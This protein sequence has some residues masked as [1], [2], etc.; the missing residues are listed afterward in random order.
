MYNDLKEVYWLNDMK[1]GVTDFVAKCSNCQQVKAEHQRPGGLAQRVEIPMWKWEMINIDFVVGI[2]CTP[3]FMA[4]PFPSFLIEGPSSQLISRRNFS[5][6]WAR[7]GSWDDHL[8]LIE[9]AYYNNFHASIQMAPFEALYGRRCRSPI[10]WFEVG[11]GELIG[12]DLVHQAIEKRLGVQGRRLGVLEGIPHEGD[13]AV[14]KEGEIESEKVVGDPSAIVPVETIE[15][16]EELSYE[17]IPVTILD[18][19]VQKFRIKEIASVK[20]L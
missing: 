12:P 1:R 20:V 2:P 6:V 10:G 4:L 15:V 5:K 18:R 14:W 8:P 19:Q 3:R 9:F 16:S 13:H 17:E 7:R 11:E